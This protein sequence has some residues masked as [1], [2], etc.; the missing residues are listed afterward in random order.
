MCLIAGMNLQM[1]MTFSPCVWNHFFACSSSSWRIS[2]YFPHFAIA[3]CP[4]C[5][6]S[7]YD[8]SAP[9]MVP[10]VAIA[11]VI[12]KFIVPCAIRYPANGS[13]A[14]LGTGRRVLSAVIRIN[15]PK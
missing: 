6:P 7:M 10:I 4:T 11:R 5:F 1:N 9:M 8:I 2:M 14:S 12:Q 13:T 3:A 15:T